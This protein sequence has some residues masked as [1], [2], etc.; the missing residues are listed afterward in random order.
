MVNITSAEGAKIAS[1]HKTS[2]NV[3]GKAGQQW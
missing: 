1:N 2:Y 3:F